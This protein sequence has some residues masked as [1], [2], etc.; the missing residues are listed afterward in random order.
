M[1]LRNITKQRIAWRLRSNAPSMYIVSPNCGFL[2]EG[3]NVTVR[4]ELVEIKKCGWRENKFIL[5]L[6]IF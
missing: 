4:I 3:E 5:R 1:F 2:I 6:V